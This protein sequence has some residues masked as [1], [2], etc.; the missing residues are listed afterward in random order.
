MKRFTLTC[1]LLL[2][3][4][5]VAFA[6]TK[7]Q[8]VVYIN[9]QRYYIHTVES[10]ETLYSIAKTYG[11]SE[12]VIIDLN[13]AELKAGENIKIPFEVTQ[14]EKKELSPIQTLKTFSRHKIKKG[15]T[16]YSISR[17]YEISIET[18]MED[19]PTIDP[20]ALPEGYKLLIRKKSVGR[21]SEKVNQ[22]EWREYQADLNLT[23]ESDGYKYHIV[24]QG[25][26]VYSLSREAGISEAEFIELNSLSGGLKA[27]AIVKFPVGETLQED[28]EEEATEEE[29]PLENVALR[30]LRYGEKL[31]VALLLPLSSD[32]RVNRHF[33]DFYKGFE[34][35]LKKVQ[36]GWNREIELTL[37][38]TNR[39]AESVEQ[40]IQSEEFEGTNL[41]VGPVYEDLLSPVIAY[42]ERTQTPVVSPLASLKESQ[43]SVLFQMAPPAQSRYDKVKSMLDNTRHVTLI[44][45]DQTDKQFEESIMTLM[46]DRPYDTHKYAYEHPTIVAEKIA[47]EKSSAGDLSGFINNDKDNTIV[48]MASSETDVDRILSALSS[49]QINIVARGGKAPRYEVLGNSEWSRYQNIDR[50]ILFKNN[51]AL[52]SSYHAKRDNVVVRKFDSEY[53]E[54]YGAI[55]SLYTYR[56]YDVAVIFGE[57]IYSDM[58]YAL[59]G[60]SFT[61]LQ[62]PYRFESD[63][64]TLIHTNTEWI[65]VNYNNNYTIT[66]E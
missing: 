13:S 51:V 50:T 57:G 56:G 15:E 21:T 28:E 45:T 37:Y 47:N 2:S 7:S 16:L 4:V 5:A 1:L 53:I 49:A 31:K 17:E 8:V 19:N 22:S 24:Q 9:G 35:G 65:R 52:L 14:S 58:D 33:A 32:G 46:G 27:G 18:I 29:M 66:I 25:E 23:T 6:V 54:K 12:Q 38:N 40:I 11:V 59:E 43:S 41:I 64:N 10:K 60:R 61:P 36:K 26:T 62:S 39:S 30:S 55:P 3:V 44:Y 34:M 48:V 20:I 63:P 42:A